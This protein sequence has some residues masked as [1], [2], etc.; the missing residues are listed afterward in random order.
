M[1]VNVLLYILGYYIKMNG[2]YLSVI[3]VLLILTGC[4]QVVTLPLN[5]PVDRNEATYLQHI[6][7]KIEIIGVSRYPNFNDLITTKTHIDIEIELTNGGRLVQ[8]HIMQSSG[9]PAIDAAML[10]IIRY[11]APYPPFHDEMKMD[12]LK[13]QKRWLFTPQ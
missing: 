4:V 2:R 9:N 10:D 6:T 13:I 5:S 11:S 1:L 8:T 3:F 12:R 7:E